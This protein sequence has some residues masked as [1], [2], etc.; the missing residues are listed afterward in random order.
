MEMRNFIQVFITTQYIGRYRFVF[1]SILNTISGNIFTG[2]SHDIVYF[3]KSRLQQ[4]TAKV[5]AKNTNQIS[6]EKS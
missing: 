3:R 4:Q 1:F 2:G 5:C 6:A